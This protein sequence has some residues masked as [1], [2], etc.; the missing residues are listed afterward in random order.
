MAMAAISMG[1]VTLVLGYRIFRATLFVVGFAF[2]GTAI[3]LVVEHVFAEETW[4]VTAS[5]V[6]LVVGGVLCGFLVLCLTSLGIFAV[7]ATAGV[8][9]AMILSD[10]FG[11]M[12]YPSQ[13]GLVLAVLCM[14]LGL[15]GGVLAI[16]LEK[17]VLIVA[18]SLFGA[19]LLLWG[20]GYFAG[21]FPTFSDLK[22]YATQDDDGKWLY[23]IPGA[24]C[25][26]LAGF[27]LLFVFGMLVQ[28]RKTG[29][30]GHYHKTHAQHRRAPYLQA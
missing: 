2:G 26:Y 21:D 11:Y 30:R 19:G 13:P 7:G 24:W 1:M 6:A 9:L 4:V 22:D 28:F 18:T 10:T 20:I 23:T 14:V 17:P 25:A 16:T 8:V 5:W 12:L 15:V 27:A 29:R 3:A